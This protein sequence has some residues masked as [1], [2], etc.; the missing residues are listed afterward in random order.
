M[1]GHLLPPAQVGA[2]LTA[3][4]AK[5]LAPQMQGK[6]STLAIA[7][8][9]ARIALFQQSLP[10]VLSA[11]HDILHNAGLLDDAGRIDIDAARDFAVNTIEQTA[12]ITGKDEIFYGGFWFGRSDI[13]QLHEIAQQ[14][15]EE[16]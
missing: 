5:A 8:M 10:G 14:F 3:Y 11:Q 13:T 1:A 7:G 2:V 6:G 15:T 16:T 12:K 4:A 9:V